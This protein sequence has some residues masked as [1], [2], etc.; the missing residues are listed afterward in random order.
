MGPISSHF[1]SISIST[2][3]FCIRDNSPSVGSHF[4][5][6]LRKH[7]F[8]I[9]YPKCTL[10]MIILAIPVMPRVAADFAVQVSG[11]FTWSSW[12]F[13]SFCIKCKIIS[14]TK[15]FTAKKICE[16]KRTFLP[17]F[18]LLYLVAQNPRRPNLKK[19]SWWDTINARS[20]LGSAAKPRFKVNLEA[21]ETLWGFIFL[22]TLKLFP[23]WCDWLCIN[24]K[25]HSKCRQRGS[26]SH[27][28]K[29]HRGILTSPSLAFLHNAPYPVVSCA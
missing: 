6:T 8:I 11:I 5:W 28:W 2:V 3:C 27:T 12:S 19:S 13:F 21:L 23:C 25:D 26:D 29:G 4:S 14:K 9:F 15:N 16:V 10:E 17:A 18:S 22:V 20:L 7:T 24:G 1:S